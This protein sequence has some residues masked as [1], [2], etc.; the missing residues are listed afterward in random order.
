MAIPPLPLPTPGQSNWAGP[1]N[2]SLELLNQGIGSV[3]AAADDA[4][5]SAELAAGYAASVGALTTF[6]VDRARIDYGMRLNNSVNSRVMQ[7]IFVSDKLDGE[8]FF[9]QLDGSDNGVESFTLTRCTPAGVPYQSMRFAGAG[10]GNSVFIEVVSPSSIFVWTQFLDYRVATTSPAYYNVV[11]VPWT[12]SGSFNIVTALPYSVAAFSQTGL[13]CQVYYD[14]GSDIVGV[15]EAQTIGVGS[16]PV[17]F[18]TY[19]R[20]AALAS[21]TPPALSSMVNVRDPNYVGQGYAYLDGFWYLYTGSG[22][23]VV[24]YDAARVTVVNA[25]TGEVTRTLVLETIRNQGQGVHSANWSEPE[26]FCVGRGVSGAPSLVMGVS[27]GFAGGRSHSLWTLTMGQTPFKAVGLAS[28]FEYGNS[29]WTSQAMA[30]WNSGFSADT[31]ADRAFQGRIAGG[32]LELRGRINGTFIPGTNIIG[33]LR[34]G[35]TPGALGNNVVSTTAAKQIV[36]GSQ[37]PTVRLEMNTAGTM[38]AYTDGRDTAN[39]TWLALDGVRIPLRRANDGI[40]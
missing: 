9:T 17:N 25:F 26:G 38:W 4:A 29:G 6:D 8:I 13:E 2:T 12:A 24:P 3:D 14:E 22:T 36:A 5:A 37:S 28:D 18:R 7:S 32:Y 11:R 1:L 30:T 40:I 10:H 19:D 15:R 27:Y 31:T 21:S 34:T 20:A 16:G 39:F 23:D 35:F 33:T